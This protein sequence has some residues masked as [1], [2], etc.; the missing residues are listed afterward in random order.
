MNK[1]LLF[2][3]ASTALLLSSCRQFDDLQD[4]SSI[5]YEAEYAI[6]LVNT[7]LSLEDILVKLEDN[8]VIFIDPDGLIRFKYSGDVITKTSDE[9]FA[10]INETLAQYP[11]IPVLSKKQALPFSS[12]DGLQMDRLDLKGGTFIYAFNNP[13]TQ[14]VSVTITLPQVTKDGVPM[15]FHVNVPAYS[16][17]GNQPI[18]TNFLIPASLADYR[19]VPDQDSVYIEYEALTSSG[20]S[21]NLSNFLV[22]IENLS[23]Y[24]AEGYLG[25]QL[26]EGGRDTIEIDFFEKWIKGDIYFENPKI[27]FNFENSF[28]IPTRSIINVFNIFTV[29]GDVLPLESEY[30]T[31]GIDFPYPSLSEVGQVKSTA[32]VFTK[33]NSNIDVVLG[34]GPVAIDYDVNAFTNPD[35]NTTIRGFITD[36]SYYKVRVDVELPLHGRANDFIARDTFAIDFSN[37][38]D[39]RAAEFKLVADNHLPLSVDVQGYFLDE[40]GVVL[41]SLMNGQ[42]RLVESGQV[43]ADGIVSQPRQTVTFVNF[44][45]DRFFGIKPAKKLLIVAGFSTANNGQG[46]VKVLANQNID[47]RLGA[48]LTVGDQ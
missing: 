31:D 41:D 40:N 39:V 48:I 45:G 30:I 15:S 28:G 44:P 11:V 23:F 4:I 18:G 19:I 10:A 12:P 27:T 29:R 1:I 2:A 13:N 33:N 46:S 8:S 36:S 43:N 21:V 5:D 6:P 9:V 14:P 26:Y 47:I 16:G 22:R 37:F 20:A 7:S 42:Q 3:A 35:N 24:Y 25:N 34:A 32:F 17:S 38:T